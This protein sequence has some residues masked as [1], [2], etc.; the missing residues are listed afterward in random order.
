MGCFFVR[1]TETTDFI[2]IH[3]AKGT[4]ETASTYTY[5]LYYRAF[6]NSDKIA[7]MR[8]NNL[9]NGCCND[10]NYDNRKEHTEDPED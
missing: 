8:M 3:D 1:P 5:L 4:L 2:L 7:R 10:S 9:A 6:E